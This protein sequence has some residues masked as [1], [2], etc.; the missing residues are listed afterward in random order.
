MIYL[1]NLTLPGNGGSRVLC[2][3]LMEITMAHGYSCY[4]NIRRQEMSFSFGGTQTKRNR[5]A[6]SFTAWKPRRTTVDDGDAEKA[7]GVSI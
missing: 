5:K 6:V 2:D 4:S 7:K 1:G 3:F